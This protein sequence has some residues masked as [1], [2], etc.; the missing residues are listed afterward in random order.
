M[1]LFMTLTLVGDLVG[2][3]ILT[4]FAD[5]LGRR[6][7]LCVGSLLMALSGVVFATSSNYAFLLAS[8]MVG[9]IS[10]RWVKVP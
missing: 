10:P 9:V 8:A 6:K 2:S 5:R 3:A 7:V 4:I 1:G